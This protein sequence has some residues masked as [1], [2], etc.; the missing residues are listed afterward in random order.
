MYNFSFYSRSP[1]GKSRD[2]EISTSPPSPG[3]SLPSYEDNLQRTTADVPH[4]RGRQ[5]LTSFLKSCVL[6]NTQPSSFYF[7]KAHRFVRIRNLWFSVLNHRTR[8]PLCRAVSDFTNITESW[9]MMPLPSTHTKASG[10]LAQWLARGWAGPA[11]C[12]Q[13]AQVVF[14]QRGCCWSFGC[15][16]TRSSAIAFF[17]MKVFHNSLCDYL[18]WIPRCITSELPPYSSWLRTILQQSNFVQLCSQSLHIW[19]SI[20]TAGWFGGTSKHHF[21]SC[22][23]T[24]KSYLISTIWF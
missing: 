12:C 7:P 20:V 14:Y 13:A 15:L 18:C 8:G 11:A 2:L 22:G 3:P 17:L 5:E 23:F 24:N 21:S 16:A 19:L 6:H 10:T 9:Q 4:T 1:P